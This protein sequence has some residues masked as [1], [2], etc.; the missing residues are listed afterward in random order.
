MRFSNKT[1]IVTGAAGG[2]GFAIAKRFASEGANVVVAD[3]N[4]G[5]IET[6]IGELKQA[7][8]NALTD[9]VCDVSNEQQVALTVKKA[10]DQYGSVDVIVNNAGLADLLTGRHHFAKVDSWLL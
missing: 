7:G 2:I 6:A 3:I 8:Y 5:K 10:I 9:A 1:V 4:P